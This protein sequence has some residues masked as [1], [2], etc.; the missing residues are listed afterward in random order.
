MLPAPK[1]LHS[2]KAILSNGADEGGHV[3]KD[4]SPIQRG[5]DKSSAK[6]IKG[7]DLKKG[8]RAGSAKRKRIHRRASELAMS[9]GKGKAEESDL[10]RAKRKFWDSRLYQIQMIRWLQRIARP[11]SI[12]LTL[13]W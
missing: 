3:R 4:A 6:L 9:Q 12:L 13:T 8:E 7:S 1:S 2:A 11:D 5:S 10:R